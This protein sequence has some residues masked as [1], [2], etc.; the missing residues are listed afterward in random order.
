MITSPVGVRWICKVR[1]EN[2]RGFKRRG[3]ERPVLVLNQMQTLASLG[4]SCNTKISYLSTSL[5]RIK[6]DS[7]GGEERSQQS[8]FVEARKQ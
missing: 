1:E 2:R 3:E 5:G 6:G 4:P 7:E 8:V